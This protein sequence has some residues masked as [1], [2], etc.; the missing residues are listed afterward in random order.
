MYVGCMS[1][2]QQ[3]VSSITAGQSVGGQPSIVAGKII[4]NSITV[5]NMPQANI[6]GDQNIVVG[7]VSH[8]V[9]RENTIA[10]G[11]SSLPIKEGVVLWAR[12]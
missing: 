5:N 1:T 8:N 3:S 9:S 11:A 2:S 6:T 7:P 10:T 4:A 12:K